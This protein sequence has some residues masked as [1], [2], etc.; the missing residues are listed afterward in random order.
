M[1]KLMSQGELARSSLE[2]ADTVT[3]RRRIVGKRTIIPPAFLALSGNVDS[4]SC[5]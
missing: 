5:F 2:S 1:C 3:E 4:R